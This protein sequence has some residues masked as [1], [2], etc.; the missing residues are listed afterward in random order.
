ML[1]NSLSLGE[2]ADPNGRVGKH[3]RGHIL[4]VGM[5]VLHAAKKSAEWVQR[6][7]KIN[8]RNMEN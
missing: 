3:H 5:C 7:Q 4:I 6:Q 1:L 8:A 2:A